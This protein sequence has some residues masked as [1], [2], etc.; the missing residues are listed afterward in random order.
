MDVIWLSRV[1]FALTIM[2]HY[3]FPPLTIGLGAM[4]VILE[5]AWLKTGDAGYKSAAKFWTKIFAL[6]FAMGVVT[7]IVMEFQFGTNWATYSRYVGDVFGSALAAEGIFAFFL[8]SGFLA[9][10]VFGWDRVSARMHFFSA[11]MVALG[12]IFSSIWIVVAN[13]WQQTPAGFHLVEQTIGGQTQV[14]AEVTDFWAVVF[15]PSTVERLVHVWIGA[16]ILGAFFVMSIT[17]YYIL[18]KRHEVFARRSFTA[19]L[20]VAAVASLAALVSGH[21][22]AKNVYRHQPAK[23]AAFEGH[24]DTG[25]G[26]APL[27]LLGWPDEEARTVRGA[28]RIPGGLSFLLFGEWHRPVMGLDQVPRGEWPPVMVSF[29]SYHI[30]VGLGMFFIVLTLL[31]L[32]KLWRGTLFQCRWL[33]WVFVFAVIG[34][35]IANELGWTAAEVGRQPWIVYGLLKTRDAAS[36]AVG[37]GEVLGSIIMFGL[38]YATLFGIW[39]YLLD[40]KIKVGP[41]PAGAEAPAGR[42]GY[43]DT[44]ARFAGH[45]GASMTDAARRETHDADGRE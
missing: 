11:L 4:L 21:S 36:P 13:S 31:A 9:V 7:G 45:E 30:M 38:I 26:G 33:L 3:L 15:N 2:F 29:Q 39:L 10:L 28:V 14:R 22:Q 35:Y 18:K 17:A 44:A 23:L 19:A 32:F 16:F 40:A 24:F 27:Y 41:E 12:S 1:Q 6:N 20:I 34:P 5:G 37:A 43:L 25:N 42:H 8:E